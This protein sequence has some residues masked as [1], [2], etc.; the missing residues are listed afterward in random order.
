MQI[1]ADRFSEEAPRGS[2]RSFKVLRIA[3]LASPF[4]RAKITFYHYPCTYRYVEIR[5]A[6]PYGIR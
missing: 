4:M 5:E 6:F 2:Q 1:N 3:I